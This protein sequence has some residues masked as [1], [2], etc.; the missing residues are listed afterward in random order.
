[1][2]NNVKQNVRTGIVEGETMQLAGD[3]ARMAFKQVRETVMPVS[4]D[5]YCRN[6]RRKTRTYIGLEVSLANR[7]RLDL[8]E[9]QLAVSIR[10]PARRTYTYI[11][12]QYTAY[13][14]TLYRPCGISPVF[15]HPIGTSHWNIH[16]S[17]SLIPT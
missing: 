11:P 4:F 3:T 5:I 12:V 8:C 10:H 13:Y 9:L 15:H 16:D 6:K 2:L 1:V 14:I 7:T 17:H